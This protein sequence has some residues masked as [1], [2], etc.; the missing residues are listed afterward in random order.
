MGEI[1]LSKVL[2]LIRRPS[3]TA[4]IRTAVKPDE[5]TAQRLKTEF[6]HLPS[7]AGQ[8]MIALSY[9]IGH[10][11]QPLLTSGLH[12][13]VKSLGLPIGAGLGSSAAFSVASSAACLQLHHRLEAS[14]IGESDALL[15]LTP[16]NLHTIN[17]W[18]FMAEVLIHGTPSGL[19]NTTSTYGG[20]LKF[21]KLESSNQY[22]SFTKI[23]NNLKILLTNTK[24]PRSTKQLVSNVRELH[25][26]HPSIIQSIFHSIEEITNHF[27]QIL[28][29]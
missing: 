17:S 22:E 16:E 28:H 20:M 29:R 10:I 24:V 26:I 4:D 14:K 11:L 8:G 3:T 15:S 27:I 13:S 7:A 19:D 1:V 12:I 23:P 21:K 25:N 5:D 18:A 6:A 2:E 9:L